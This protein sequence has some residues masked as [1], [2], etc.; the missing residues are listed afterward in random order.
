MELYRS[1]KL[2]DRLIILARLLFSVNSIIEM[3][4][5]YLPKNGLIVDLG[6]GYGIISHL[7]SFSNPSRKLIGFDVSQNR[8]KSAQ[9][10]QSDRVNFQ[11][12][13]IKEAQIPTCNAIVIIDILYL[14]PY[15]DQ[16]RVLIKCFKKL[17]QDGA[18][19]IKD[20]DKSSGWRFRWTYLEEKIKTK[21]GLYG[22]EIENG[23]L[24]YLDSDDF[25]R[26]LKKIGFRVSIVNKKQ[27]LYPGIFYI[28]AKT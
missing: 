7:L 1:A 21:L 5:Q 22:K 16:E 12:A 11:L 9:K 17:D 14:L 3:L 20:T 19:I 28:C 10:T 24:F 4:E 15:Q 6:C 27:L 18:L 26:L 23:S 2:K 13:D 25:I 8:I